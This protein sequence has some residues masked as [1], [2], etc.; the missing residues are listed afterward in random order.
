MILYSGLVQSL[1][2]QAYLTEY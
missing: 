2:L 1:R